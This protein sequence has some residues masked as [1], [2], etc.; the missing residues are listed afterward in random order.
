M[1]V[2]SVAHPAYYRR[3]GRFQEPAEALWQVNAGAG[4]GSQACVQ[5]VAQVMVS[6]LGISR[7]I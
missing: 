7:V 6:G 4:V 1:G 5:A 2:N 3:Q